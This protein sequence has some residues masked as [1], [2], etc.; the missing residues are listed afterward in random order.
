M[1][2]EDPMHFE[3]SKDKLIEWQRAGILGPILKT[4]QEAIPPV[5]SGRVG[6]YSSPEPLELNLP[7]GDKGRAVM[8]LQIALTERNFNLNVD[9]SFG[10]RT[11][12]AVIDFQRKHGLIPNGIV[13]IKTAW[14]LGLH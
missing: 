10:A 12:T 11:E 9:G 5:G 6:S 14:H 7:R 3:V 1:S 2:N 13:G 4:R 8:C